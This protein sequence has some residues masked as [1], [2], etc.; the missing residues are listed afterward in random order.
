[1]IRCVAAFLADDHAE[2]DGNDA[3]VASLLDMTKTAVVTLLFSARDIEHNQ[4]VALREYLEAHSA[5]AKTEPLTAS[6]S[7]TVLPMCA[8]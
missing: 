4:A 3:C 5:G 2:L 7:L 6:R 1:M 8:V